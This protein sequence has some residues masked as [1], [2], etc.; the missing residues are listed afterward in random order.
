MW[1]IVEVMGH[2]R[3]AGQVE[4][5]TVV[6]VPML[7]IHSPEVETQFQRRDYR[8]PDGATRVRTVTVLYPAFHVDVAGG[9]L[10]T[11]TRC[12]ESAAKAAV[13]HSHR[14]D[15]FESVETEGPWGPDAAQLTGPVD[16]AVVVSEWSMAGE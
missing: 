12:P 4:Q 11:V 13:P 16:D 9:A 5:V 1:A 14:P 8:G 15:G 7:R 2:R 10:F 6:G 3:Y